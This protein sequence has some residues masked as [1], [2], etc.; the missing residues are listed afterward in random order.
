MRQRLVMVA[1]IGALITGVVGLGMRVAEAISQ[2]IWGKAK[3][4]TEL[5]ALTTLVAFLAIIPEIV[6]HYLKKQPVD[7]ESFVFLALV[8]IL[9]LQMAWE[10]LAQAA[11]S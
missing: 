9:I 4:D 2:D 7:F 8:T 5:L 6:L 11:A 1:M 3:L 10:L